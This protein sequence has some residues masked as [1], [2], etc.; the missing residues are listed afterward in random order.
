MPIGLARDDDVDAPRQGAKALGQ[1]VPGL[2]PHDDRAAQ[3]EA[4]E[5]RQVFRQVPGH[6]AVLA[7][8]SIGGAR[9]DESDVH[10]VVHSSNAVSAA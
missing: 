4:F 9:V 5:M 1:R 6:G 10:V 8:D 3:R 2:A 7:D